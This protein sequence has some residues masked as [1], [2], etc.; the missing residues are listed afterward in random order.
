MR[1]SASATSEAKVRLAQPSEP[2]EGPDTR[3]ATCDEVTILIRRQSPLPEQEESF[4][5]TLNLGG[6]SHAC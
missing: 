1:E 4:D 5:E 3:V 6:P 2:A